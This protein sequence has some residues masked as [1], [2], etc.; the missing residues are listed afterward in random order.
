MVENIDKLLE[1]GENIELLLDKTEELNDNAFKF[2][3][4]SKRLHYKM[5]CKNVKVPLPEALIATAMMIRY[6][7]Y[8][9]YTA[10]VD[11]L[12]A[13]AEIPSLEDIVGVGKNFNL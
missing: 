10:T 12:F 11:T 3:K 6:E 9:D 1:R 2:Q 8:P 13:K 7:Q 4:S 5:W